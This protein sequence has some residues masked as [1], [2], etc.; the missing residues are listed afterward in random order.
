MKDSTKLLTPILTVDIKIAIYVIILLQKAVILLETK[1]FKN[2]IVHLKFK[3][4]IMYSYKHGTRYI[5]MEQDMICNNIL[6]CNTK[7]NI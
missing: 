7:D 5:K 3:K 4:Y 2:N 6:V 1:T